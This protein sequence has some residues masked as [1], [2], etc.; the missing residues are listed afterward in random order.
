M[1][2]EIERKFLVV[3][4][5]KHLAIKRFEIAQGYLSVSPD[6]TVRIRISDN[7]AWITVKSRTI[8]ATRDEWEYSVPLN[9]AREML[10]CCGSRKIE[11]TRYIIDAEDGLRWEIDE[12]HGRHSGLV[13]AEIEL[14]SEETSFVKPPYIGEEVTGDTRYYNSN[15]SLS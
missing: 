4:P 7:Q 6:S 15:L 12:F 10:A 3:G 5:F 8:G 11:K 13:I 2:V 9:D 1:S 14:P